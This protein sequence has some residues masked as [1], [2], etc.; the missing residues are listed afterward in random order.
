[1]N[2]IS[3]IGTD[4]KT[5]TIT[6]VYRIT[7]KNEA[8]EKLNYMYINCFNA[9][10]PIENGQIWVFITDQYTG[11]IS[12]I[13]QVSGDSEKTI[14]TDLCTEESKR[15]QQYGSLLIEHIIN[16]S[17]KNYPNKQIVLDILCLEDVYD[18]GNIDRIRIDKLI[19][20]YSRLR[21]SIN[22]SHIKNKSLF[23]DMKYIGKVSFRLDD[24]FVNKLIKTNRYI[25]DDILYINDFN[26]VKIGNDKYY[27]FHSILEPLKYENFSNQYKGEYRK[28][29]INSIFK[30]CLNP[31]IASF[32]TQ[33]CN[34]IGILIPIDEGSDKD[35][36]NKHF[37]L[38]N[39]LENPDKTYLMYMGNIVY[40]EELKDYEEKEELKDY[41][42]K[43]EP[44]K[45][46]GRKR[47]YGSDSMTIASENNVSTKEIFT[48]KGLTLW[49]ITPETT[50][51]HHHISNISSKFNN[52][53]LP[54]AL[55][56]EYFQNM[57]ITLQNKDLNYF[58]SKKYKDICNFNE[59]INF[60]SVVFSK[61]EDLPKLGDIQPI[62]YIREIYMDD[63]LGDDKYVISKN[64]IIRLKSLLSKPVEYGDT[65]DIVVDNK[66][67]VVYTN[68][69]PTK[70]TYQN[71]DTGTS[72]VNFHVHPSYCN[73]EQKMLV[74]WP[75]GS[76]YSAVASES[77]FF[78]NHIK[79]HLCVTSSGIFFIKLNKDFIVF[80]Q[81]L[82]SGCKL[83]LY[84]LIKAYF[85]GTEHL[86]IIKNLNKY[87]FLKNAIPRDVDSLKNE[88][89]QQINDPETCHTI[90]NEIFSNI[91]S[92]YLNE[93]RQVTI[94][95]L[96]DI[97]NYDVSDRD[98]RGIVLD[99]LKESAEYL[100]N[101]FSCDKRMRE[102]VNKDYPLYIVTFSPWNL[103]LSKSYY[104]FN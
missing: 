38:M 9:D 104:E 78:A 59:D 6:K 12:S 2:L 31:S 55:C 37:Y 14:I 3:E 35:L 94:N 54:L 86:R 49:L 61:N 43:E 16:F 15:G 18:Y 75:S 4:Y 56:K 46:R 74:A 10:I 1:M 84:K 33:K 100:L 22:N 79:T 5:N 102:E 57:L 24:H 34:K 70:G 81:S 63:I 89:D 97:N 101:N 7:N 52:I 36:I 11:D 87:K 73:R 23:L 42:E 68:Q 58:I 41:E 45:K 66:I 25:V 83:N 92:E 98:S 96:L 99:T 30:N 72:N 69:L 93:T 28:E 71:V 103:L 62:M 47:N 29:S 82:T 48:F 90:N 91:V 51:Y 88:I 65:Y 19:K 27:D 17:N 21:F 85:A 80:I 77:S 32:I 44:V 76:D 8:R 50:R 67:K 20:F 40:D 39:Y 60:K 13:C 26:I 95:R 53:V 64:E